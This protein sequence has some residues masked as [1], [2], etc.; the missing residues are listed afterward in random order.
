MLKLSVPRA[1]GGIKKPHKPHR[2]SKNSYSIWSKVQSVLRASPGYT[3]SVRIGPVLGMTS[4]PFVC[5]SVE[6]NKRI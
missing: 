2:V 1:T 4:V 5:N 6:F 3:P